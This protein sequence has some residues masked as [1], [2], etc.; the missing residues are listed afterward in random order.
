MKY[1][2]RRKTQSKGICADMYLG[3]GTALKNAIKEYGK[4]SF[5]RLTLEEC[6]SYDSLVDAEK[7]WIDGL[8]AVASPEYYNLTRNDTRYSGN[9]PTVAK[10]IW[11]SRSDERINEIGNQI[12]IT[13]KLRGS[14]AG[15]KNSMFGRS[16]IA[17]NKLRW[18]TN[19]FDTIYVTEGTEPAGYIRGRTNTNGK[20]GVYTSSAVRKGRTKNEI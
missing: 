9:D 7:K 5:K 19:G 16:A 8:D 6:D 18:Y 14:N 17:E 20:L 10:K 4:E 15:K 3:S 2:G 11:D 1:V 12:S 13:K